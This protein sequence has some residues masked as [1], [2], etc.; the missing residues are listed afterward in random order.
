MRDW[1]SG[2]ANSD[3]GRV[4][5]K[6]AGGAGGA[7]AR[8]ISGCGWRAAMR[9]AFSALRLRGCVRSMATQVSPEA[10]VPRAHASG[11][12]RA[13]WPRSA[14]IKADDGSSGL[15]EVLAWRLNRTT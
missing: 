1:Q 3:F 10:R 7:G 9:A 15:N 6:R 2:L 8:R 12:T 14:E 5:V 11:Q 4:W 13:L